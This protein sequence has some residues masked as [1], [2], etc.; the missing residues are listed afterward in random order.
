MTGPKLE[1]FSTSSLSIACELSGPAEGR[2]TFMLHGWPDD[3]RT[4]DRVLP[5]LHAA[6]HRLTKLCSLLAHRS[7]LGPR[8]RAEFLTM[9]LRL[10]STRGLRLAKSRSNAAMPP[11]STI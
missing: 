9:K 2:P 3:A 7:F 10:A 6:G 11:T 1:H 4:W 8:K 5:A